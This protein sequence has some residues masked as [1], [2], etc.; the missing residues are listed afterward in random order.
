MLTCY[1]AKVLILIG[2]EQVQLWMGG[3]K[4]PPNPQVD[5]II[6]FNFFRLTSGAHILNSNSSSSL[7][8]F[9]LAFSYTTFTGIDLN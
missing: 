4:D 3:I 5:R 8:S 6:Q 9:I 2:M 1:I 7:C